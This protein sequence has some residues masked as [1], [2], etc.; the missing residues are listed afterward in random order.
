VTAPPDNAAAT[1]Y[2]GAPAGGPTLAI[3]WKRQLRAVRRR[4]GPMLICATAVLTLAGLAALF[5]P[6]TYR[7][8]GTILI[9]QQEMPAEFVRSAI[10]SY[11]DQRVHMISQRVMTS[12]NLLDIISKYNLYPQA[13]RTKPREAIVADMRDD[14][15]L[16]MISADVVDP[17]QGRATKA[18][19]AFSVSYQN[20]S[21][22]LAAAVA[23]ELTSLYLRENLESRKQ[24][25]A[26]TAEFLGTESARIGAQVTDLERRLADFKAKNEKGLPEFTQLNVQLASRAQDDLRELDARMR[27]LDQQVVFL[28]SQLAQ[29]NP[30]ATLYG[31][32]GQRVLGAKDQLK[33]LQIQYVA[34]VASHSESHPDVM[35]LKREIEGLEKE[36]GSQG[37]Y[38]DTERQLEQARADL[39]AA[40]QTRTDEHP[41]VVR[42]D[43]RVSQLEARLKAAPS[44]PATPVRNEQP[45]NP[46]YIQIQANRAAAR[47]ER[48]SLLTQRLQTRARL[49]ELEQRS[50]AIPIIERDY[51]ALMSELR[52]AQLKHA[53]VQQ[54][55]M[56]AQLASNLE[57]ERK[58]ERFTLIEPPLEP[59]KP[60]SPN[61]VLILV[62]G[63]ALA[64]G[65]AIGL[66]QL[67]EAFDT[68]IRSRDDIIA[69]LSVPPLAVIPWL[70]PA[71]S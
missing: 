45:D 15:K 65:G 25:A 56:E 5:W 67:L 44:N 47:T 64:L 40:R 34:A 35:R 4:L 70:D 66:M 1:P 55:Q 28:D 57:T 52:S 58:G 49:A 51:N 26:G 22:Q 20:H 3:L 63:V 16:E 41:D 38:R 2:P 71:K 9:E 12:S 60:T 10:S 43:R 54:K 23:N 21:P 6:P 59:Q 8:T 37:D 27:S 19:I 14:I 29:I 48:A 24:Q 50:A 68:R 33:I 32:T 39:A 11:A 31:D 62:L 69:L 42:L 18:T 46:A 53:E 61:L 30:T 36:L 7:S 17:R 13:R